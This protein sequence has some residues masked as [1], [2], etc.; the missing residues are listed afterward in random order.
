MKVGNTEATPPLQGV[1]TART[2]SQNAE[3]TAPAA[4]PARPA[5]EAPGV[6]V[7]LSQAASGLLEG[8]NGSDFD[9]EKVQRISQAIAD[10]TFKVD[11]EKIADKLLANAQEVLGRV[12]QK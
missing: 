10:G 1:G 5:G 11:A 2:N 4:A 8:T 3:T 6:Q 7:E 12:Q 9:V